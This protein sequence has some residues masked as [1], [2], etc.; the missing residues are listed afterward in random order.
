MFFGA[1]IFREK[2]IEKNKKRLIE[3]SI[4]RE[5]IFWECFNKEINKEA[6]EWN[7]L[8]ST[9][10]QKQKYD[11]CLSD[12]Q[13]DYSNG[14]TWNGLNN[15][16]GRISRCREFMPSRPWQLHNEIASKYCSEEADKTQDG[17]L[18]KK[19]RRIVPIDVLTDYELS[20]YVE[21]AKN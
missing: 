8:E 13:N 14:N 18:V 12:G 11:K 6:D 17:I 21:K 9:K 20:S 4:S 16:S 5:N 2:S 10:E 1:L 19:L 7:N 15:I 3:V